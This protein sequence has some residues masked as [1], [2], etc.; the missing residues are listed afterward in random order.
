MGFDN[1]SDAF[2]FNEALVR[3]EQQVARERAVRAK[4]AGVGLPERSNAIVNSP[5][6]SG[7]AAPSTSTSVPLSASGSKSEPQC[8][9]VGTAA[10]SSTAA[11]E[12]EGLYRHTAGLRLQEGQ[13]IRVNVSGMKKPAGASPGAGQSAGGFLSGLSGGQLPTI[14][15][16]GIPP[17]P[18]PSPSQLSQP[19]QPPS[20]TP[21]LPSSSTSQAGALLIRPPALAP[22]PESYIAP[23]VGVM[24]QGSIFSASNVN[25]SA[26]GLPSEAG[27]FM[28]HAA[29]SVATTCAQDNW[30]TF[31]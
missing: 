2:D 30:A 25:G 21:S 28:A 20:W 22:P 18:S 6:S 23:N 10:A 3:H 15:P 19:P 7:G 24:Q 31:D 5:S 14:R 27:S 29:C 13:T 4:V 16:V 9:G 1:R 17:P 8:W 26:P 12:I 11:A